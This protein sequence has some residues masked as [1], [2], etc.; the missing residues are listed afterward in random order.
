MLRQGYWRY[1]KL[2][3]TFSTMVKS[4]SIQAIIDRTEGTILKRSGNNDEPIS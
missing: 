4:A 1:R 3:A 2:T